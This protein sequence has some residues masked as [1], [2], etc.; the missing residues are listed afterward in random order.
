MTTPTLML[1]LIQDLS[2]KML[3]IILESRFNKLIAA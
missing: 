3:K 1:Y 2:K